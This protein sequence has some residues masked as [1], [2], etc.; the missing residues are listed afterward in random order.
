[1][2]GTQKSRHRVAVLVTTTNASYP[3]PPHAPADALAEV[4]SAKY[5]DDYAEG[6]RA[7][8]CEPLVREGV[9]D[10]GV[11]DWLRQARPISAS[12]YVKGLR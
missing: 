6:I 2:A 4:D 11:I 7:A 12:M 1:M 5:I 3:L 9:P 10:L 8:G